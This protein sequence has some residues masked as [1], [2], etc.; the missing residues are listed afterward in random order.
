MHVSCIQAGTLL[1]R[2]KRPEYQHCVDGLE[3]YSY[4]YEECADQAADIKRVYQQALSG[5]I[6]LQHM[7]TAFPGTSGGGLHGG[8][9]AGSTP[10][11]GYASLSG[12]GIG[13]ASGT[14]GSVS[15]NGNG[16]GS[17]SVVGGNGVLGGNSLGLNGGSPTIA[18]SH[19]H[20]G[21]QGVEQA[22]Y[23]GYHA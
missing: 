19:S 17:G 4:A 6:E 23:G 7:A 3:Q 18:H 11:T 21:M 16:S 5:E 20:S 9:Q 8:V 13:G 22:M 12:V 1:A 10:Q 2:L 14:S 15:G